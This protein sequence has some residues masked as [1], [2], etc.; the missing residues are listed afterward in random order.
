VSAS[1][2]SRPR[3]VAD[4]VTAPFWEATRRGVL[5]VQTTRSDGALHW[6]P[7]SHAAPEWNEQLEWAEHSGRATLFTYSVVHRSPHAYMQRP[8]VL[9]IVELEGGAHMVANI[10]EAN[11]AELEIGMPLELTWVPLDGGE[12]LPVFRPLTAA[13]CMG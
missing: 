9:A 3:P 13:S 12:R 6:P 11:E 4:P 5:M 7:R 8:Y 2:D 10:V 1:G